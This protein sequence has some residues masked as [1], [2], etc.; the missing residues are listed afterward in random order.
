MQPR[1]INLL[2]FD[3]YLFDKFLGLVGTGLEVRL[4][5]RGTVK[6]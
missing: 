1:G 3:L 6:W 2:L 5:V 4:N